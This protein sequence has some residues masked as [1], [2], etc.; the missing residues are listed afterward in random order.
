[1]ISVF[2]ILSFFI[3]VDRVLSAC[4]PLILDD[5]S[6]ASKNLLGGYV[7]DDGTMNKFTIANKLRTVN[8]K[9]SASYFYES[10]ICTGGKQDAKVNGWSAIQF[11][12][13]PGTASGSL[14]VNLQT[15]STTGCS[16]SR[17]NSYVYTGSLGIAIPAGQTTTVVIPFSSFTGANLKNLLSLSF[18][19]IAPTNAD[20]IFGPITFLCPSVPVS[21]TVTTAVATT[22][23]LAPVITTTTIQVTTTATAS[24]TPS[25]CVP[26]VIDNASSLSSNALGGFVGHDVTMNKFT[27]AGNLRTMN[28]K[29]A[30]SYFYESGICIGGKQDAT[31]YGWTALQF[32]FNPG[33]VSSGSLSVNLQTGSTTGCT[34]AR[35]NSYVT[36]SSLGIALPAGKLT[37]VT[38]PLS[39]FV[40]ANLKNILSISFEGLSPI[41]TDVRFGP[42]SF[43]CTVPPPVIVTTTTTL[44]S[45]VTTVAPSPSPYPIST[46]GFCGPIAKTR[47]P[48]S[49][50]CSDNGRCGTTVFECSIQ[51]GCR[52]EFGSR[53]YVIFS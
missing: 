18:E 48:G 42:I 4:T 34:A 26:F 24:A 30:S 3:I 29:S 8:T 39:S 50:C 12:V 1:M 32:S 7:G 22:T 40:G 43:V 28:A 25:S 33:P 16:A 38:I 27:V 13:N 45:T 36:T 15:G 44:S 14:A 51:G 11:S 47:C 6:N 23:T 53:W 10:G 5:F 49:Q 19:G 46:D 37:T 17:L 2:A 41:A 9:S 35:L 21:S 31:L 52:P 20:V